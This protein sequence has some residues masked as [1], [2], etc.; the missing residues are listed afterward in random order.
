LR[1][2]VTGA[3]GFVGSHLVAR[4]A[5]DGHEVTAAVRPSADLRR[6]APLGTAVSIVRLELDDGPALAGAFAR[7]R[8]EAVY[9][10]ACRTRPGGQDAIA[11][12][13]RFLSEDVTNLM[14]VVS[15]AAE[16]QEPPF[17]LVRTGTLAE[18]GSAPPPH[19]E[20]TLPRP[21]TPY[22]AG[23][24]AGSVMLGSLTG[25]TPFRLL[26]LRLGLT[27][28]PGQDESFLIPRIIRRLAEREPVTV[29]RPAA[30]RDLIHVDDV[31]AALLAALRT[32]VPTGTVLNICSGEAPTMKQV[33]RILSRLTGAP[34]TLL[35]YGPANAG[36]DDVLSC[37][38][39]A[40]Q[41]LLSWRAKVPL[42]EGLARLVHAFPAP[43]PAEEAI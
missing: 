27:Y 34:G 24:L 43:Q 32:P 2:L 35:S 3:N 16:A 14:R 6:L 30:R 26:N 4:L 12:A 21:S 10:L 40:A 5:A 15:A 18:Y 20:E 8:P 42:E 33:A 13:R 29:A 41:S 9:H 7:A 23:A 11:E 31:T 28:G 25:K 38:P 19:T 17:L 36:A 22:G 1:V 37:D 39:Q